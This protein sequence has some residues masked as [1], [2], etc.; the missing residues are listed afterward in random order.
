MG[1]ALVASTVAL[2]AGVQRVVLMLAAGIWL[3]VFV[4]MAGL[5]SRLGVPLAPAPE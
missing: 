3:L 4:L 5:R 1:A 2:A